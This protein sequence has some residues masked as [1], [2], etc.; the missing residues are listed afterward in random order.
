MENSSTI[1]YHQTRD[2]SKKMTVTFEFVRENFK[3]LVKSILMIAGPPVVVASVMLGSFFSDLIGA[4]FTAAKNPEI[5]Q[6]MVMSVG[7]W[8]QIALMVLFGILSTVLTIATINNYMLLYEEQRTNKVEVSQVWDRVQKTFWMY[9]G[10][11]F[12]LGTLLIVAL[13]VLAIFMG[14][15]AAVSEWLIAFGAIAVMVG[16]YY[17]IVCLTF[18]FIIRAYERIGFMDATVRSF[19]LIQGKW[20]STFGLTMVL[21]LI[22]GT[23]SSVFFIPWYVVTLISMMHSVE[24]GGIET[25]GMGYN[26]MTTIFFGLYYLARTV[27]YALPGIG[28]AFQ[29]FNLVE[30]KESRGLMNQ[31]ENFGQPPSTP[32]SGPEEHY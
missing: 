8:A 30:M 12:L 22:V 1:N 28:I 17:L 25:P 29:Y 21:Y 24:T 27:L 5:I 18:V 20:W 32:S 16:F 10:T 9:L 26:I 6:N 7:F 13:M 3:P 19:K 23:I 4:S 31:I 14:L 2:F 11:G 15:L